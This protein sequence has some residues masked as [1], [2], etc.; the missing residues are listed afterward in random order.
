MIDLRSD[1]VTRP[2]EGMLAAMAAAPV[3][4]DVYGEDPEVRALE[5]EAAGLFGRA[6]ALFCVTGSMANLLGV[7]LHTRPGTEVLCDA[8]AHIARAEMGAHGALHGV[9]MRTWSSD[10]GRL[11]AADVLGL[12]A[13][14][15]GPFLVETS[16]I[17]VEDTHNFGGGTV[18]SFEEILT[19]TRGAREL[20]IKTHLD[21]A[22]L[23]NSLAVTGRSF[24]EHGAAFDTV[25]LCLSKGL[26]APMG[27]LLIGDEPEI[28]RARI[29]RKRLGGG[30]RQA[31]FMAAAA[32]YAL[33]HNVERISEDHASARAFATALAERAEGVVDAGAV[34]TNVV[35]ISC[36]DAPSV[37][38][39]ARERGVALSVLGPR[40]LRVVTHLDASAQDCRDAGAILGEIL[41]G[42]RP[43]TT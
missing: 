2:S 40:Q 10:R 11:A 25:S 12:A 21:G 34:E 28:A 19:V 22:R 43:H 32:R 20:G 23:A 29:Q 17:E 35:L 5:E 16:C 1:T 27:S 31:G 37:A 42:R 38:A 6:A 4:D 30:W 15:C 13:V 3:G 41:A 33:R 8:L 26:G 7:W 14:G 9:T 18:Q 36:P 24:A 39:A